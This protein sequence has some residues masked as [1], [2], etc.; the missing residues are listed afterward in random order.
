[1][2]K[3]PPLRALTV[4]LAVG[5]C[6]TFKEAGRELNITTSAV[7]HQIKELELFLGRR[8]FDRFN[9]G[10]RLTMEG[11]AYFK[12]VNDAYSTFERAT[13]EMLGKPSKETLTIHS[14]I[15]FGLRWLS[16]RI[17]LFMDEYPDIDIRILTPTAAWGA[18]KIPIDVDIRFGIPD[19]PGMIVEPLPA[20]TIAPLCNPNLLK[21]KHPLEKIEDL[22]NFRLIDS[23][24]R[25]A[26]WANIFAE[27]K[28]V[29]PVCSHIKLGNTLLAL[30]AARNGLGIAMEGALLAREDLLSGSLVI[31][32]SL[33]RLST[34]Q[35]LRS[36]VI[37]EAKEKLRPI[38]IFREWF[39]EQVNNEMHQSF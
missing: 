25:A 18:R 13:L 35:S 4:F 31:P 14:G 9:R 10:V 11:S 36:L 2:A 37:S 33:K 38:R 26:S 19:L 27:N 12:I 16:P 8:M 22:V 20:E 5:R 21:G 39:F 17:Q 3:V 28:L 7:S 15:S 1:M 23:D 30:E 34:T 24:I 29:L 32:P 6:G